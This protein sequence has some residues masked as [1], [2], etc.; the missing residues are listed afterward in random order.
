MRARN[1]KEEEGG[2]ETSPCLCAA[3]EKFSWFNYIVQ[4]HFDGQLGQA[5][6]SHPHHCGVQPC[7]VQL[8]FWGDFLTVWG[9]YKKR[10]LLENAGN[11][12]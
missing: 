11:V 1:E 8:P 10:L 3:G 12:S 4:L 2:G 6:Q 9:F 7:R 5:L